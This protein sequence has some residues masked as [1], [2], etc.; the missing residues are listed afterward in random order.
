MRFITTGLEFITM[1]EKVDF[2]QLTTQLQFLVIRQVL[3]RSAVGAQVESNEFHDALASHD[4]SA[5]MTYY[6]DYQLR[7]VL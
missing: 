2:L 4:V 6:I 5:E 7:I 3:E 1:M